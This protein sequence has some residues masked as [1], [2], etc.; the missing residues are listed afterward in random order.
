MI[1]FFGK[2]EIITQWQSVVGSDTRFTFCQTYD[3]LAKYSPDETVVIYVRI[4][5]QASLKIAL[6]LWFKGYKVCKFW[7]GTDSRYFNDANYFE[8]L[9]SKII[10]KLCIYRNFS[11]ATWLS[12]VLEKNGL[13]TH[14]W[15]SCSPIFLQPEQLNITEIPENKAEKIEKVLVYSNPDRHWIYNTQMMLTLAAELPAVNFIFVGD[16]SLDVQ[17]L[18]N[19]NS[20]GRI[21]Q[22]VL[23]ELYQ[24]CQMLVRITSH[25]GFSRM[26][27]EG[28][29]F[30]MNVI[31]NWPV[32]H[33]N[34]ANNIKDIK[35][36]LADNVHFN[37]GGYDYI[38][39][40]FNL[41]AWKE[42]LLS[43]LK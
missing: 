11:P 25:D 40:E 6:K 2:H 14:Y 15:Q 30:G 41:D 37:R 24:S 10:Y 21:S 32:P 16:E 17:H 27:I 26:I 8:K 28:M 9:F 39:H 3:Q 18:P 42:T 23:F 12:D 22:E 5:S 34:Y 38:R 43:A 31:T 13:T 33:T 19:V 1:V 35:N 7:A 20:L 4:P 29:Y 36:I